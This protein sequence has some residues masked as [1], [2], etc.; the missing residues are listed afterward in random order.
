MSRRFVTVWIAVVAASTILFGGGYVVAQQ[1]VR[2]AADHPQIEMARD[3]VDKLAA[4][5]SPESVLPAK[6]IDLARSQEPYLI[7]I[8]QL[9]RVLASSARLGGVTVV[10]PSGVFD[11]VRSHGEDTVSWQP[12]PGVRSAIVVDAF[13]G[14]FVVA[15]R[16]LQDTEN[17][18]SNLLLWAIG[19]WA[20]SMLVLGGL[21]ALRLRR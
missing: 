21:A 9:G 14:G 18:E 3:A 11:Y 13:E 2:H 15:G 17:L 12:A 8:D 5:A 7:V 6:S 19:G 20:V 16:S 10:P 1:A 4:G